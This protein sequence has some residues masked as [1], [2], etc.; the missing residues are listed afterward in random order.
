MAPFASMQ[1][2]LGHYGCTSDLPRCPYKTSMLHLTPAGPLRLPTTQKTL[3]KRQQ[4]AKT[5]TTGSSHSDGCQRHCLEHKD[6]IKA[7]NK[8]GYRG[9]KRF[10]HAT[11]NCNGYLNN[12]MITFDKTVQYKARQAQSF[13]QL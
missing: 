2:Q 12:A 3:P 11:I 7:T 4:L 1:Y 9:S 8:Y 13:H 6:F 10:K 5:R